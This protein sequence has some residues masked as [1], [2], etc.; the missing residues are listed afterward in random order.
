MQKCKEY[1][2]E[3]L[4]GSDENGELCKG[5]VCFMIV[6]LKNNIISYIV[7]TFTKKEANGE[8]IKDNI[9][10]CL[11]TIIDGYGSTVRGVVCDNQMANYMYL[12]TSYPFL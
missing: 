12:Q 2:V 11:A 1:T 10:K 3:N 4:C 9:L 7:R 5:I 6:G 8:W